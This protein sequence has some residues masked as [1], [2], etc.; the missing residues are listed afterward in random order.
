MQ[1]VAKWEK[2]ARYL[3]ENKKINIFITGS[4]SKFLSNEFSSALLGR[5]IEYQITP[6]SFCEFLVFKNVDVS[7]KLD[8]IKNERVIKQSFEEFLNFGGFPKI[9]LTEDE[10]EKRKIL[11]R[12]RV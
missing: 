4:N 1:N 6:L 2:F 7:T 8:I 12:R 11:E 3:Y 5:Y 9:A 10:T